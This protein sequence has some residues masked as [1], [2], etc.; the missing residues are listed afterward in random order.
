MVKF[1][2]GLVV[3]AML[4]ASA[5]ST[6]D[7]LLQG[8]KI[9]YKSAGKA[10]SIEVPPD[11]TQ[12]AR[13]NRFVVPGSSGSVSAST[14]GQGVKTGGVGVLAPVEGMRIER[15]G[16]Q[17]YLVV[18]RKPEELWAPVREFWQGAR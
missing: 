1:R 4:S 9:D 5:C 2:L 15:I 13:D 16:A 6:V 8:D 17:R 11:L 7:N 18:N 10:P 12:L 14:F 3:M